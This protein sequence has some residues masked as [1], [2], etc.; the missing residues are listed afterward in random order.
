MA[1]D[2]IKVEHA[3]IDKPE[4]LQMADLLEVS[5]DDVLGKLIRVWAWFDLQSRDG[6]AGNVTGVTLMKFI[7]RL[8]ARQGFAACMK[9]VGWLGEFGI[10]NFDRHN[11]ESSKNRALSNN[12]Q[13]RHRNAQSVTKALPE[14]RR[15][16]NK[17]TSA[18]GAVTL[19][20]LVAD[21]LTEQTASEFMQLRKRKRAPLTPT[22]WDGIKSE[23]LKAGWPIEA[24]IRKSLARGWQSFDA[25]WVA[26]DKPAADVPWKGAH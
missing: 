21:G 10:P 1:G 22:A 12:R 15:E 4:V 8:V 13:K 5:A 16:E 7:D 3:T 2:W 23:A 6:H 19:D 14:K 25:S 26:N 9:K 17:D 18:G 20:A 24:A 11:G